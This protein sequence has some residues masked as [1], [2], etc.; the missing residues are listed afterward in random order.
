MDKNPTA[1]LAK[2]S[3]LP[4]IKKVT[5]GHERKFGNVHPAVEQ[6]LLKMD[7]EDKMKRAEKNRKEQLEQ[8]SNKLQKRH[9]DV[10]FVNDLRFLE[11]EVL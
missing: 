3:S 5:F 4:A 2:T 9:Q 11:N 8:R 7:L 1:K 6:Q 10:M